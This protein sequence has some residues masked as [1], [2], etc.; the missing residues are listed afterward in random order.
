MEYNFCNDAIQWQMSKS[1]NVLCV[2]DHYI[3][4]QNTELRPNPNHKTYYKTTIPQ[5]FLKNHD[6]IL[7]NFVT[8]FCEIE[9]WTDVKQAYKAG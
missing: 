7:D 3:T 9:L 8:Y 6:I 2:L 4:E 1:T 5:N